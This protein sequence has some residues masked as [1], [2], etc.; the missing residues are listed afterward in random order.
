MLLENVCSRRGGLVLHWFR[1][2]FEQVKCPINL[3]SGWLWAIKCVA[4]FGLC[5]ILNPLLRWQSIGLASIDSLQLSEGKSWIPSQ[6]NCN[7]THLFRFV[8]SQ[9]NPA[10][11]PIGSVVER[12]SRLQLSKRLTRWKWPVQSG[13]RGKISVR[14]QIRLE[15]GI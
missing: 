2:K 7:Y 5:R 12:R 9:G 14:K 1:S 13:R 6:N 15:Q 8:E 3:N 11:G 10:K 4:K